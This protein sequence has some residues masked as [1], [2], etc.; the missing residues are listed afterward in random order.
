MRLVEAADVDERLSGIQG[1][2]KPS[3]LTDERMNSYIEGASSI[4]LQKAG[5]TTPPAKGKTSR[6]VL[7]DLTIRL[8]VL[9]IMGDLFGT[10]PDMRESNR[11]ER[12]DLLAEAETL[13][14]ETANDSG[15]ASF[16]DTVNMGW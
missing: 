13:A 1:F 15:G 14:E 4:I 5:Y 8:S 16:F 9:S 12:N 10:N 7:D 6:S 2:R 3:T 11:R